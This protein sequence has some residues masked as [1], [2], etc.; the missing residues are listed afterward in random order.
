[1]TEAE[2][3]VREVEIDLPSA[4]ELYDSGLSLAS[5]AYVLGVATSTLASRL[6]R[7]GIT[8]RQPGRVIHVAVEPPD[9]EERIA[10][11]RAADHPRRAGARVPGPRELLVLVDA[12]WGANRIAARYQAHASAVRRCISE[13][14]AWRGVVSAIGGCGGR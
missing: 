14:Q 5:T 10:A 1:M 8:T 7:A 6:R 2:V 4:A 9:L 12:G 11:A 3:A 13:A